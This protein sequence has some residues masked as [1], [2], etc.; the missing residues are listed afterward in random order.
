[1]S[2]KLPLRTALL[3]ILL[4]TLL[5]S[6]SS[7]LGLLYYQN[8]VELRKRDDKYQ[9]RS[10]VQLCPDQEPLKTSFLCELI[11]LSI[12]QPR[13]LYLF[14]VREAETKILRHPLIKQVK[15]KKN[16]PGTLY[17]DYKMR[18]PV[19][20]LADYSNTAI[21]HEGVAIPFKPFF[22]PKKLPEIYLGDSE[23]GEDLKDRGFCW[24]KCL[25]GKSFQLAFFL[26]GLLQEQKEKL[27]I[28]RIDVSHAFASSYGQRQIVIQV[29]DQIVDGLQNSYQSH[30]L[31]LR[32]EDFQQ[33]LAS[34]ASL[35]HYFH[36]NKT[37][38]KT[39]IIDLRIPDLAYMTFQN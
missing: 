10:I 9:I 18:H 32:S 13:N 30:I 2:D 11:E 25:H 39:I 17:I 37:I 31:R 4:I 20:F 38:A 16:Y 1:M 8:Q 7:F 29:E 35:R 14:D 5:V 6:G 26:L 27:F 21:D 3:M 33:Q 24:G 34:Y 36:Q 12:D 28:Q 15:V 19:A 22:S 23:E